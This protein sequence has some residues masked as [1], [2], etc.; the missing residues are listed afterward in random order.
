M[1]PL[2]ELINKR[3]GITIKEKGGSILVKSKRYNEDINFKKPYY[4]TR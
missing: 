2:Q 4:A 3:L 1:T